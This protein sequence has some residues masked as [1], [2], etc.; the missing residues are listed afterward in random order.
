MDGGE[1]DIMDDQVKK[2]VLH[3]EVGSNIARRLASAREIARMRE[4]SLKSAEQLSASKII[5]PGMRDRRVLNAFRGLR[6]KL[7]GMN[8]GNGFVVMISPVVPESG[9]SFTASNLA[10]AIALDETKTA[11]LVDCNIRNPALHRLLDVEPKAGLT[12]YIE[13]PESTPVSALIHS[14]GIPRLRL[15]PAG[16]PHESAS[17]YYTSVH[18]EAFLDEVRSRYRE[19]FV[20][21]DAPSLKESPDARILSELSDTVILCVGYGKS[22]R[23]QIAEVA[24]EVGREKLAGVVFSEGG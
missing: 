4:P 24:A 12:D 10:S 2:E 14:T 5:H 21:I 17:D 20:L 8:Q 13:K 22:T 23:R 1:R 18:M 9:G 6:T 15:V 16:R 7:F 3:R 11:L 19:R